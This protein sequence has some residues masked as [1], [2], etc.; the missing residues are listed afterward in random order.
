MIADT[1]EPAHPGLTVG[2][3]T[4]LASEVEALGSLEPNCEVRCAGA[5]ANRAEAHAR[6]LIHE[7]ADGLISFGIAGGLIPDLPPG[8]LVLADWVIGAE[9]GQAYACDGAWRNRIRDAVVAA[10][11]TIQ[12]KG[13][14]LTGS[15][16]MIASSA[17]KAALQ[18]KSGAVA[19]D[20]ESAAVAR[21]AAEAGKPFV[22]VRAVADPAE[23]TIPAWL[24]DSVNEAGEPR[25]AHVITN[26]A[27]RPWSVPALIRV[28]S[29][30]EKALETLR[31]VALFSRPLFH[32]L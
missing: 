32:L 30:S 15:N 27:I 23:R 3:I 28:A 10:D 29:D 22:V 9:G 6:E 19:V 18:Q 12:V 25:Y 1:R 11:P 13:G 26:L 14:G 2:L 16:A 21:V 8:S 24:S 31:R 20:M 7:G 17:G 5:R 4:G